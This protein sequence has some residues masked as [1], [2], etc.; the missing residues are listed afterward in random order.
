MEVIKMQNIA[1]VLSIGKVTGGLRYTN[2][3]GYDN[4]CDLGDTNGEGLVARL[5]T[6][7]P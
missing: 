7:V 5:Q 2:V 3:K 6:V 4:N 1:T